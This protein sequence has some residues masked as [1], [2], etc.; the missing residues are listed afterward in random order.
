MKD[1]IDEVTNKCIEQLNELRKQRTKFANSSEEHSKL[2]ESTFVYDT[3]KYNVQ[4]VVDFA[5][6]E[7]NQIDKWF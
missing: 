7:Y 2:S 3:L 4:N 1:K 6:D 5:L